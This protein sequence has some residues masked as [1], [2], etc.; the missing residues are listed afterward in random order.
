MR[1]IQ[2]PIPKVTRLFVVALITMLL[3]APA[4]GLMNMSTV[5]AA[6]LQQ[7]TDSDAEDNRFS[8]LLASQTGRLAYNGEILAE[9]RIAVVAEASGI[10]LEVNVQVGETVSAGDPLVGIDSTILEAE[11]ELAM[12]SLDAAQAQL[13]L[14]LEEATEADIEAAE[15]N[16]SAA[17]AAY[18]S[19]LRGP[20]DEDLR[21]A[22]AELRQAEAVTRLA[23]SSYNEVKTNPR[24]GSMPQ[25]LE[26]ER[27]T[28]QLEAAQARYAK[29][30]KDAPV[31]DVASAYAQLIN[32]RSN[33]QSMQEGISPAQ[34]RITEAQIKQ[35]ET[36][37]FLAQLALDNATV[38]APVDGI[39][40]A[41]DVSVG[42]MV[43]QGNAV[44]YL[45]SPDVKVII[46]VEEYR[47]STL[48]IGQSALIRVD[49]YPDELFEGTVMAIA[50]EVDS[51]TRTVQVTIRPTEQTDRILRPGMF[52]TVDL[53]SVEE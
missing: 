37:L 41:I 16:L 43:G 46:P 23:Q 8:D 5:T 48:E 12:V 40:A 14:L 25:S 51:V 32:A 45:L 38:S 9:H 34:R 2:E 20:D 52:A 44:V 22:Q 50:P 36:R 7:D 42:S 26:L 21:I 28:L 24:I 31:E 29:I 53:V 4:T 3:F 30:I 39:V 35:A 13:E 33:L 47:L 1:E 11:K 27:A 15:A 18:N 19:L 10:A 49:A 17:E 6:S